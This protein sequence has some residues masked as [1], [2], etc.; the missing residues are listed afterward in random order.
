MHFHGDRS[1]AQGGGRWSRVCIARYGVAHWG[2]WRDVLAAES[3]LVPVCS[4]S[5]V[6]GWLWWGRWGGSSWTTFPSKCI[7][8][9]LPPG[10]YFPYGI[11]LI[12]SLDSD[13]FLQKMSLFAKM[14]QRKVDDKVRS[15]LRFFPKGSRS[16]ILFQE[17]RHLKPDSPPGLKNLCLR[18]SV[19]PKT[20]WYIT[21]KALPC[22]G[23]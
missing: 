2:P 5:W 10:R 14:S 3:C 9:V 21:R 16:I 8:V 7:L 11:L 19:S 20:L 6:S 23:V 1:P 17:N 13:R 12:F 22:I 4:G 15:C 18:T